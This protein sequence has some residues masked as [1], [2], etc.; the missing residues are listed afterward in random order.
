[1]SLEFETVPVYS[2]AF[3]LAR[4][5]L[6]EHMHAHLCEVVEG[7]YNWFG[8]KPIRPREEVRIWLDENAPGWYLFESEMCIVLH[9]REEH[10]FAFKLRWG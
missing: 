3:T 8:G 6:N 10:A 2:G 7:P 9:M 5:R 4:T 1:M